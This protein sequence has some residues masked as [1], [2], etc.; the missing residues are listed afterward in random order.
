MSPC[1]VPRHG[2]AFAASLPL[3]PIAADDNGLP[4]RKKLML[5]KLGEA[6]FQKAQAQI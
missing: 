5:V 4:G 6:P 1:L 3:D 2:R